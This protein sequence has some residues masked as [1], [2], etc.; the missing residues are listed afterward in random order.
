[1]KDGYPLPDATGDAEARYPSLRS[2]EIYDYE[3]IAGK[4]GDLSLVFG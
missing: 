4:T 2:S 3:F 1:V